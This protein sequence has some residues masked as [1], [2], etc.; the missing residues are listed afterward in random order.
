MVQQQP[1]LLDELPEGEAASLQA[2]HGICGDCWRIE[3][4]LRGLL[5]AIRDVPVPEPDDPYW[6]RMAETIMARI[7]SMPPAWS[8]AGTCLPRAG[9]SSCPHAGK[10]GVSPAG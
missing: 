10:G 5:A 2:H 1:V 9:G 8:A 7:R 4:L 3:R 6:D